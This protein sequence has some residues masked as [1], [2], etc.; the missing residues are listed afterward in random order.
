MFNIPAK[1]PEI[2]SI[3]AGSSRLKGELAVVYTTASTAYQCSVATLR[4]I[5]ERLC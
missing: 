2:V 5:A 4:T 1:L 3:T